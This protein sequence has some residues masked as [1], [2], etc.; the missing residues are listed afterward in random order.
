VTQEELWLEE[1]PRLERYMRRWHSAHDAQD[2]VDEAFAR[3]RDD[4][5]PES[6]WLTAIH[7]GQELTRAQSRQHYLQEQA[8]LLTGL[9]VGGTDKLAIIRADFDR[10]FRL[11]PRA[12]QEA[13][14]LTELRGLTERETAE[15][16]G[17][18]Q[19]TVNWRC[20]AARAY[21]REELS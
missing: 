16:L 12:Q 4:A 20:E 14:A 6:L 7:A 8:G 17:I 11:L 18:P 10:A 13:F 9:A 1:R 19:S 21:L 5:T 15:V 3:L 2:V